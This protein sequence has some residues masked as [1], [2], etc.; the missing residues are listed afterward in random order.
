MSKNLYLFNQHKIIEKPISFSQQENK[1]KKRYINL[2]YKNVFNNNLIIRYKKLFTNID[3]SMNLEINKPII[4]DYKYNI[5]INSKKN[6]NI[7][8]YN[9]ILREINIHNLIKIFNHNINNFKSIMNFNKIRKIF[10]YNK[11]NELV[12]RWC[13][14]QYYNKTS[15]DN[16]IP[17]NKDD[18]YNYRDFINDFNYILNINIDENHI[19]FDNLKKNVSSYLKKS[20][21]KYTNLLI[22]DKKIN[23]LIDKSNDTVTFKILYNNHEIINEININ[24]Y[25]RLFDKFNYFNNTN[26]K[27]LDPNIYIFC[28][29]YRYSY[30]DSGQQQLAIDKRIKDMIK[31][32]GVDFELFGSAIN[33]LSNHYCSL[34]Y[35]IEKY[36]GSKGD[37]FNIEINQGIFW[38]NPP[39]DVSLMTNAALKLIS[40]MTNNKNVAFIITIPIWDKYTQLKINTLVNVTKNFNADSNPEDHSDYKIYSL[41]KPYIKS[42]LIIPKKRIPYFNHRLNKPIYAV[43]TYM[44]IVYHNIDTKYVENILNVFDNIVDLDKKDYFII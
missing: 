13:W 33:V 12:Q 30:I 11:L 43:N 18:N 1:I 35:D 37:F 15:A 2:Y 31:I 3:K 8:I 16:V 21:I 36:F 25:N 34:F 4:L 5:N 22:Q 26:S 29:I 9:E 7:S 40:I 24:L 28:L 39:Y 20:Y 6:N 32:Y 23:L 27:Q 42:E 17:Y 14:L 44:L 10:K 19:I 41:L 38:C